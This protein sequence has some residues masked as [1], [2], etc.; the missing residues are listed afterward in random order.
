ML[1]VCCT[2]SSIFCRHREKADDENER[3]RESVA[4]LCSFLSLE[5][6]CLC[7]L[8]SEALPDGDSWYCCSFLDEYCHECPNIC[9]K[10]EIPST[11]EVFLSSQRLTSI[12]NELRT[13]PQQF[14]GPI[15]RY[16]GTD[17]TRDPRKFQL[18][19]NVVS[20]ARRREEERYRQWI[21]WSGSLDIEIQFSLLFSDST[22]LLV[23]PCA[24]NG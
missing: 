18:E 10:H 7:F 2:S 6:Q 13:K 22:I 12:S 16:I 17:T 8:L 14:F 11:T 3:R 1:T 23:F 21:D 9:F 24:R 20:F 15:R 5:I 19:I 4:F